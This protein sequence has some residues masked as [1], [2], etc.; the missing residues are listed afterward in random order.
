MVAHVNRANERRAYF[1]FFNEKP[2]IDPKLENK[3]FADSILRI[4]VR[5][6]E[7]QCR[8][9]LKIYRRETQLLNLI[10]NFNVELFMRRDAKGRAHA[11]E[12]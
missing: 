9:P 4:R 11:A 1:C 5:L 10:C 6:F 8:A 7:K 3:L 12:R 2:I